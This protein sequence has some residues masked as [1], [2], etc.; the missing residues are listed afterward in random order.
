MAAQAV[1]VQQA[2]NHLD[3]YIGKHGAPYSAWYSGVASDPRTRLFTDHSVDEKFGLWI[4]H[5]LTT[6]TEARQVES[7]FLA[8]GCKGAPGGGDRSSRYVYAYRVTQ[9]TRE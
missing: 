1:S 6:D 5:A 9:T 3:A 7:H 8:K 4:Y 2:V